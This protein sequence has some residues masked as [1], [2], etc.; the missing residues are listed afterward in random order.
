MKTMLPM[1]A[2]AMIGAAAGWCQATYPAAADLAALAASARS[3]VD[4]YNHRDA[5][6]IAAL[7]LPDG[8]LVLASGELLAGQAEIKD[9]YAAVFAADKESKL[10]LEAGSVRFLTPTV[11][12]EDGTV[13]LTAPSGEVSS[14]DYAAVHVRQDDGSWRFASVRDRPDDRAPACEKLLAL[15]WLVGDWLAEIRGTQTTLTF[16]WSEDGPFLDGKAVTEQAGAGST[17]A[18]WRI[19]WDAR[20]M[21]FVSWGF[22]AGGGYNFSEWTAAPAGGWL[23]HTRGVTA[24]GES[25][26]LTQ[27]ITTGPG[28]ENFTIARRDH[29]IDDAVQPDRAVTFVKRPPEPQAAAAKSE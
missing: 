14:T 22:D 28:N 11:A 20:R 24:D 15:A 12:T 21:G 19:G 16:A 27:I 17:A 18:T 8:E 1:L 3:F 29:V 9:H 2:T 7:F 13:H 25:N 23:L 4:A 5:A 6:A 10:A 26:Q